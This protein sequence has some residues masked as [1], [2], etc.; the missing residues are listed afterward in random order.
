[1]SVRVAVALGGVSE[2][3]DGCYLEA[4]RQ[5]GLGHVGLY[6][7]MAESDV[8]AAVRPSAGLVLSGG[9]DIHPRRYG[10]EPNGAEMQFVSEARDAM[11]WA[12]L[13]EADR[14][15]LPIL[16][17]CRGMQMLNVFRGGGLLQDV[18]QSHRDGRQ[19]DEKWRAFHEV[20]LAQESRLGVALT[21]G[22]LGV[23]SRHHQAV[24]PGRLGQGL[25]ATGWCPID[26]MIEAVEE[27]GERFVAG[28]QW[29]PENMALGP[30]GTPERAN[31]EK[32]FAA[33]A[34]A[35]TAR[36]LAQPGS[37]GRV[38]G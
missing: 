33:F 37:A 18:G 35:V 5:A 32:L 6:P 25:R 24:D 26:G 9:A 11:E 13:E 31:A 12:A 1:M 21:A 3:S 10:E 8:R 30:A 38:R 7:S 19:Q 22:P 16:A 28:V 14:A 2:T 4:L 17:I 34:Q 20:Q 23:N 29:H 15:G 27:D 36:T